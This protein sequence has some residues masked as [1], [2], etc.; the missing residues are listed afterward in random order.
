MGAEVR[1][2]YAFIYFLSSD[3]FFCIIS[4]KYNFDFNINLYTTSKQL[5]MYLI[6]I[7]IQFLY[8]AP[9]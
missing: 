6:K 7:V 8:G 2:Q 4:Q 9:G 3:F 5:Y 1:Y